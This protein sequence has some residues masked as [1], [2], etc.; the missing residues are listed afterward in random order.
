[1]N[2]K[3]IKKVILLQ[4]I[5]LI[6][7]LVFSLL[8]HNQLTINMKNELIKHEEKLI[9][10]LAEKH[11]QLE[12]DIVKTI[13]LNEGNSEQGRL[14]LQKYGLN[15]ADDLLSINAFSNIEKNLNNRLIKYE[16]TFF[17]IIILTFL[18]H[19]YKVDKKIK[20]TVYYMN[21]VLNGN[22]TIDIRDYKEDSISYLK[23][24][25]YKMAVILKEKTNNEIK[26]KQ[27]L[28]QFLSDISHQIKTP[29]T[30]MYVINDLLGNDKLS[31]KDKREFL[32]KNQKQLERI[33]W[34]VTTLLK[35]S[36]LE[37]GTAIL[38]TDKVNIKELLEEIKNDLAIPLELK[39]QNLI[40]KGKD[41]IIKVDYNWTLESISNIIKNAHEHTLENGNIQVE[42]Q[43]NPLYTEI[44]IKDDGVGINKEDL[45]HIFKRFYKGKTSSK[46]SIGIGLH[47]AKEIT[48][49]QNGIINVSS[50]IDEGT[51]FTIKF[52]KK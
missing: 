39:R 12:E 18:H 45:P 6:I 33:E 1:M 48:E 34:L 25:I 28:E 50:I 21:E 7:F 19:L 46:E 13:L 35:I 40:I 23:N 22:Y 42:I 4:T 38:K 10:S 26:E 49:K 31:K 5:M 2:N 51:T 8:I 20:E 9:S 11:P 3:E 24:E 47:M 41:A 14:L 17:I 44:K 37:S 27:Q 29:L 16:V 15:N 43:D 52:Y 30:S 32:Q 36:R